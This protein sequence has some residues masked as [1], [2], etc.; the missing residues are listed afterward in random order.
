VHG[1]NL[2]PPMVPPSCVRFDQ[3]S[4]HVQDRCLVPADGR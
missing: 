3:D 1:S 4:R 2:R